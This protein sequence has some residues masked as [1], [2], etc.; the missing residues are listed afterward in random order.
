MNLEELWAEI[1]DEQKWREEEIRFLRKRVPDLTTD[2]ERDLFRRALILILYAHFEGFC[3][4][5][6]MHYV[7][8]VNK[9]GL[10]CGEVDYPIAAAALS[11]VMR[12]LR[13]PFKKC[14]EFRRDLPDDSKLHRFARDREFVE[15]TDALNL[16]RATIPERAVDMESNLK[17]IVLRKNLYVLGFAHDQFESIERD[18]NTLLEMRNGIAHGKFRQGISEDIYEKLETSVY[19]IMKVVKHD[20]MEALQKKRYLRTA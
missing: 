13:D 6:F 12:A 10:T 18:I 15:Q 2:V 9:E 20:I 1:E 8:A 17:P 7:R 14:A 16:R 4:F 3:Y 19:Q 5:T 11:D